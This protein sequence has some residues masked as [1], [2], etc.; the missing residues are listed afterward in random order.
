[1]N[2]ETSSH[3]VPEARIVGKLGI[4]LF[5]NAYRLLFLSHGPWEG[6]CWVLEIRTIFNSLF[7]H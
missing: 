2:P 1:M 5:L 6:G 7:L 4:M 3:V